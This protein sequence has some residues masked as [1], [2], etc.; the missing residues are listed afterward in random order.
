M[1]VHA[2][3]AQAAQGSGPL[4]PSTS[5]L[6]QVD[7][8]RRFFL[9]ESE[10][11]LVRAHAPVSIVRLL[12]DLR[13]VEPAAYEE[14]KVGTAK[15]PGLAPLFL[16][17]VTKRKKPENE[18]VQSCVLALGA[19]GDNDADVVDTAI[20]KALSEDAIDT[21]D[22]QVRN[23]ALMSLA[24]AG[25]RDGAGADTAAGIEMASESLLT[26]LGRGGSSTLRPWAGLALG[27]LSHGVQS[28]GRLDVEQPMQNVR[29]SLRTSLKDEKNPDRIGA[30]ALALGM[31]GD[32]PSLDELL[33]K[34]TSLQQDEARGYVAVALGLL[35]DR[36]A[37]EPIQ[38][39]VRDSKYRPELLRQ[40][41]IAL[42]LLGDQELV[43]DLIQMLREAKSLST[44]AAISSA[45]G[46]IGDSR[47]IDS[48]VEMLQNQDLTGGA[49]GF[50]AAALGIVA[51]KEPLPWNAKI[52]EN[53]NYR[54]ST[55]TLGDQQGKG[56][57][58]IL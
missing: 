12:E 51:D 6:A 53:L 29:S 46:Y 55:V 31:I 49:R 50:A 28:S 40:A 24:Q 44:Q 58:N 22:Q 11:Y 47:S 16:E 7:Y 4:S 34:L 27:V 45:L 48:L 13:T 37:I 33:D 25:A 10:S 35:D 20:R 56:V 14:M 26:R 52:G 39:I 3:A 43:P 5:R 1:P 32:E 42:G 54:A 8:L 30:Y 23:F 15:T 9:D 38:N 17:L 57:L 21:V 18:I 41:A 2:V 36:A 19:L